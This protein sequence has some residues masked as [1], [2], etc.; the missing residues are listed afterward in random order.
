MSFE[1][2]TICYAIPP[3][4]APKLVITPWNC[5]EMVGCGVV[6]AKM[7]QHLAD[8]GDEERA[9]R[10]SVDN[11]SKHTTKNAHGRLLSDEPD[12]SYEYNGDE[13]K[14]EAHTELSDS[15]R[16]E[17]G[18]MEDDAFSFWGYGSIASDDDAREPQELISNDDNQHGEAQLGHLLLNCPNVTD[19]DDVL[20]PKDGKSTAPMPRV[21]QEADEKGEE[22][23]KQEVKLPSVLAS[24]SQQANHVTAAVQPEPVEKTVTPDLKAAKPGHPSKKAHKSKH[25]QGNVKI[26]QQTVLQQLQKNGDQQLIEQNGPAT[27]QRD[28]DVE[29]VSVT[30]ATGTVVRGDIKTH[31]QTVFYQ[32][33]DTFARL[34]FH[35]VIDVALVIYMEPDKYIA[36]ALMALRTL[37]ANY[38]KQQVPSTHLRDYLLYAAFQH[39]TPRAGD[40]QING[41]S[42]SLVEASLAI[43]SYNLLPSKLV[44]PD[45]PL[46]LWLTV[47]SNIG[48]VQESIF[49]GTTVKCSSCAHW[50]V[51][52][53]YFHTT[54]L[55][56]HDFIQRCSE[57]VIINTSPVFDRQLY[58]IDIFHTAECQ[59]RTGLTIS[60]QD[61]GLLRFVLFDSKYTINNIDE[62]SRFA[63]Q[64]LSADCGRFSFSRLI[65]QDPTLQE[66]KLV[67]I[68][69]GQLC[70]YNGKEYQPLST[71]EAL[72]NHF[73]YGI[74]FH[75][76]E[77]Q[78][79]ELPPLETPHPPKV[80]E[81]HRVKQ[82]IRKMKRFQPD[83]YHPQP[84]TT[85]KSHVNKEASQ[86]IVPCVAKRAGV[87]KNTV[88]ASV[89]E[90]NRS[91]G[92][93][94]P[95]SRINSI[96]AQQDCNAQVA[97]SSSTPN[98]Q[99]KSAL[100]Q[101][102]AQIS[103]PPIITT[104]ISEM[105][106]SS[107]HSDRHAAERQQNK[108]PPRSPASPSTGTAQEVQ[109][110][111]VRHHT[112]RSD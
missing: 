20:H 77:S 110:S 21:G 14:Q 49:S 3:G 25:P 111:R 33:T 93:L 102:E 60:N 57:D 10:Y 12:K 79:Q 71:S 69:M 1:P 68:L 18:I 48:P 62:L 97:E 73:I 11:Q 41:V 74:V 64:L 5:V 99:P 72:T 76:R 52:T 101:T 43:A 88:P 91:T 47:F 78:N 104:K 98:V 95:D 37:S 32:W 58:P 82:T 38:P 100:Q 75:S 90:S 6:V 15:A 92:V 29:L 83:A 86:S 28:P 105:Q 4:I 53:T 112:H 81:K 26:G 103:M 36:P 94:Q 39:W 7:P 54:N 51:V 70:E 23:E 44:V 56:I 63:E 42:F 30:E 66:L 61:S 13:D 87:A 108:S 55:P 46:S 27:T 59:R 107:Y 106:Q 2:T 17:E 8:P 89:E 96:Q 35:D 85:K 9:S 22:Q 84:A 31:M 67:E 24:S 34:N 50:E 40:I 45:E 109:S 65:V 80:D 19:T 16:R